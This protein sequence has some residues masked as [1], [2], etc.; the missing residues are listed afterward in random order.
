[1]PF[2]PPKVVFKNIPWHPFVCP[3]TGKICCDIF[4]TEWSPALTMEKV[5]ISILSLLSENRLPTNETGYN[6]EAAAEIGLKYSSFYDH[7]RQL[8]ENNH[9]KQQNLYKDEEKPPP[10]NPED[11]KKNDS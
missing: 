4:T 11:K 2:K 7:A 5:I 9:Y 10:N 6:I 1:M 8:A 3:N